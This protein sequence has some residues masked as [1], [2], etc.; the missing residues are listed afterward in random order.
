MKNKS[1]ELKEILNEI[2]GIL[3]FAYE[4]SEDR[5]DEKYICQ[6]ETKL[7]KFLR[8]EGYDI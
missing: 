1:K 3:D 2:S 6:T 8:A 5:E 7:W 4:C